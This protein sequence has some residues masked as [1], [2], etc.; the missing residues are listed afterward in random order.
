MSYLREF[1]WFQYVAGM[2]K[3]SAYCGSFMVLAGDQ[4][5]LLHY[6]IIVNECVGV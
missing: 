6:F 5:L 4:L 3:T 2:F 1:G